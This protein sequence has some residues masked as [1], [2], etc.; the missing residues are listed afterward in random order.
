M[1]FVSVVNDDDITNMME[2]YDKLGLGDGITR[3]RSFFVFTF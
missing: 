2:E 3:L 1:L